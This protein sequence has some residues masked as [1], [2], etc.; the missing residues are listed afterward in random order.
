MTAR[1][2]EGG[3]HPS[4]DRS[5]PVQVIS[6]QTAIWVLIIVAAFLYAVRWALLPFVIAALGAYICTPLV[7]G[8]AN[9]TRLPR[10]LF[11]CAVFT[12]LLAAATTIAVFGGPPLMR[13]AATIMTDLGPTVERFARGA[14]GDHSIEFLGQPMNASEFARTAVTG[15]RNWIGQAG[16][17]L[18][19][20]GWSFAGLFGFFLTFVLLFFFLKD[21]PR[22]A[23]GVLWLVPPKHRP[24]FE[25]VWGRLDPVLKRYFIGVIVVVAY[26]A[27]AAY[28][29]LGVLLGIRHAVFLALLTGFLEMIPMIGPA[30]SAVIAGLVAVRQATG[31]EAIVAYAVYATVLRLS[32]DQLLGPVVLGRAARLHPTVIIFCFLSGGLLFGIAG[33]ILA[34][35]VALTIKVTLATLYGELPLATPVADAGGRK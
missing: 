15:L 9:R 33:M 32:I 28:V 4:G 24:L 30:A 26:A 19:L 2:R 35:P 34:V 1:P 3:A 11:A 10:V 27:A 7:D 23:R 16:G 18:T 20:A 22:L 12:V 8:F 25:F 31:F 29:G 14:I 21:G 6:S 13:E 5:Q 17:L